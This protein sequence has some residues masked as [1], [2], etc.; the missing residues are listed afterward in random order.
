MKIFPVIVWCLISLPSFGE[1]RPSETTWEKLS[2][3]AGIVVFRRE[4][5]GSPLVAFKGEGIVEAPISK[6]AGVISDLS[7][8]TEWIDS[9]EDVRVVRQISPTER[10]EYRHIGT[11]I[12]MTDRDFVVNVKAKFDKA[13][14]TW[15]QHFTSVVDPEAPET[16]YVRGELMNTSFKLTP[17]ANGAQTYVWVEVHCDPKGSVPK[18]IVNLFQRSWA[19][20]TIGAIRKQVTRS[21]IAEIPDF[22]TILKKT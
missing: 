19:R 2:D 8:A 14:Q 18:W 4:I 16:K 20:N 1:E 7:H 9:L 10:I 22:A 15:Y 17:T 12:V 5:P 6:V 3:H 11:P 13:T 21:D